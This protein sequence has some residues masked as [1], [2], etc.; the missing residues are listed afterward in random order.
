MS[1]Q[2][3]TITEFTTRSASTATDRPREKK[4]GETEKHT[5]GRMERGKGEGF[6][7]EEGVEELRVAAE[8]VETAV[9]LFGME[10]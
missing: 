1:H 5:E 9:D 10:P 6:R 7:S 8:I 2:R 3:N 4:R